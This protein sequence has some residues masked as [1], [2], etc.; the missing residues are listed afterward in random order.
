MSRQ[1]QAS[2]QTNDTT[3]TNCPQR[4]IY[5]DP[6]P[7]IYTNPTKACCASHGGVN[8]SVWSPTNLPSGGSL[9]SGLRVEGERVECEN[10]LLLVAD[11]QAAH[12]VVAAALLAYDL[13]I[14]R[15][16][17]L[18]DQI[19]VLIGLNDRTAALVVE[20]HGAQQYVV[21]GIIIQSGAEA[22][23]SSLLLEVIPFSPEVVEELARILPVG[24]RSVVAELINQPVGILHAL[25][26]RI[27][28][29]VDE[30]TPGATL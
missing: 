12:A 15:H 13:K 9:Q 16:L 19:G 10:R 6:P 2:R 30:I 29:E 18:G 1:D 22:S 7:L 26:Q 8:G 24:A 25:Y 14:G 3:M 20:R 28:R 23:G 4:L 27:L 17:R 11:G 21:G 5:E